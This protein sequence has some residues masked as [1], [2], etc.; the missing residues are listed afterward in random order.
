MQQWPTLQ[1]LQRRHPGTLHKFFVQH[2]CRGEERIQQRIQAIYAARPA[3]RDSAL[4]EAAPLQVQQA[5][6]LIALLLAQI[7]ELERRIQECVEVH[8]EREWLAGLPGAG[9]ALLPRL[10]VAFGTQRQRYTSAKQL[11]AYSGIAPVRLQSGG[12]QSVHFRRACPKFLRQTF[13]EFAACSRAKSVWAQAYYQ[14]QRDKGQR[15]HAAIRALAFKWIRVL[16]TCW[17]TRTPYDEQRYMQSRQQR[18]VRLPGLLG[19]NT[20]LGWQE[21]NGFQKISLQKT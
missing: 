18:A 5:A 3:V 15:H 11:Q 17:Q 20:Q 2:N 1:E 14:M 8:P 16:Y 21:V 7:G 4:L 10:M 9:A 19:A 13:Q 6:T 12:R